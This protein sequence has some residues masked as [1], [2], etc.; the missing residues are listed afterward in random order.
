M[1]LRNLKPV[2]VAGGVLGIVLLIE[3]FL[4]VG[5]GI[6]HSK[7]KHALG[8]SRR[9]LSQLNER[10]PFPSEK[11]V[12]VVQENLDRFS[13]ELNELAA[14]LMLDPFPRGALE[15]ANFSARAQDVIERIQTG[16]RQSGI[17]I[18]DSLEAGF[19][20]YASGGTV[21]SKEQ[22]PRLTRQLYSVARVADVLLDSRVVSIDDLSREIFETAS[23]P[24][25]QALRRRSRR[26]GLAEQDAQ[27]DRRVATYVHPEG[28][29]YIERVKIAFTANEAAVW[30]VLEAFAAAPHFMTITE[31][32]HATQ[33]DILS[34]DPKAVIQGREGDDETL[35][36]LSAGILVGETALSRPERI[37]AGEED[38]KVRLSVDVYNFKPEEGVQ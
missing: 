23:E 7:T 4:L 1:N 2:V 24:D 16:A 6:R 15:A 22:V 3:L 11:N 13:Y 35:Q 27:K 34:Y 20:R 32:S 19:S 30:Q 31:F 17:V 9:K 26:S 25:P 37:I 36:Y 28:M 18:P 29:Y 14:G 33:T 38:L 10:Q 5:A 12:K 21:P 8:Q